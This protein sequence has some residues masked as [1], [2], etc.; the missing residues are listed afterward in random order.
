MTRRPL[1]T[2]ES[3]FPSASARRAA[4]AAIDDLDPSLPLTAH[5]DA[6]EAAYHRAAGHS[7]FRA[8][9]RS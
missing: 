6:W 8:I 5:L 7:P 2:L 1:P 4:D 9:P 3:L